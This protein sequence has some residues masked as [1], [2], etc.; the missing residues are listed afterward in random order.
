M[1]MIH[2]MTGLRGLSRDS[3]VKP[4]TSPQREG[5][6]TEAQGAGISAPLLRER[7]GQQGWGERR[8]T[9]LTW[10]CRL[11]GP[12]THTQPWGRGRL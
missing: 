3:Q 9:V 12:G 2:E 4:G 7:V 6:R 1:E 11:Q 10:G 5:D 8:A